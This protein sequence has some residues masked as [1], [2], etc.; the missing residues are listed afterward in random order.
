[1]TTTKIPLLLEEVEAARLSQ[2][3]PARIVRS[4]CAL[5]GLMPEIVMLLAVGAP[6]ILRPAEQ[7]AY[8]PPTMVRLEIIK[9]NRINRDLRLE[10]DRLFAFGL[11]GLEALH[12]IAA[13]AY[14]LRRQSD[15]QGWRGGL[16]I[17]DSP[18]ASVQGPG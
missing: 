10:L 16:L 14:V 5:F 8:R 17:D 6:N 7:L 13:A 15:S 2:L 18:I 4:P 9:A 12:V 11:K 1:M 3:R